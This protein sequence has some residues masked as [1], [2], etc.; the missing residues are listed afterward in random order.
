MRDDE[1]CPEKQLHERYDRCFKEISEK[2]NYFPTTIA[3]CV[4]EAYQAAIEI[5]NTAYLNENMYDYKLFIMTGMTAHR[6]KLAQDLL[7]MIKTE[8]LGVFNR[9][10][11]S[12]ELAHLR[13][14]IDNVLKDIG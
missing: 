5:R 3:G 7:E 9:L 12:T 6:L 8:L 4:F 14:T 1:S 2:I 11:G 10:E 13:K